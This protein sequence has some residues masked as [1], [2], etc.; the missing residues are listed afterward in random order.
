M[1]C[2]WSRKIHIEESNFFL[3]CRQYPPQLFSFI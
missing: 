2:I 3:I 1:L